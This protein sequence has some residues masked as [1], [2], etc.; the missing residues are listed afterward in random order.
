MTVFLLQSLEFSLLIVAI[1]IMIFLALS[2]FGF[3]LL[4]ILCLPVLGY[5][6][7]FSGLETF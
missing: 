1:L 2:L 3:I 7:S 6:L 4:G 5:L